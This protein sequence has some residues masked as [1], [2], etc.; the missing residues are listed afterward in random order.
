MKSFMLFFRI[1]LVV[2]TFFGITANNLLNAEE[3]T[4]HKMLIVYYSHT[5][6]AKFVAGQIQEITGADIF[7]LIP[8]HQYPEDVSETINRAREE[9]E[10]GTLPALVAGIEN[11]TDYD[12]IFI[13]SPNWFS[14][15]ALPVLTFLDTHDL[16]G[17]KVIPFITYGG[18]GL[19]NTIT[20]L[21]NLVPHAEV[22]DEFGVGR[23]NVQTSQASILEWLTRVLGQN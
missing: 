8:V 18:G 4:D 5:G 7:E 21:K 9:R 6:N 22:L 15:L 20:D 17:K 1:I 11:L 14:T 23:D 16:S 19:A 2:T 10:A 13:G 12:V 3:T